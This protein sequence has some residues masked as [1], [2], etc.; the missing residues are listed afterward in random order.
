MSKN[1]EQHEYGALIPKM[2]KAQ[3]NDLYKSIEANGLNH[4]IVLFEGKVLDGWNRYNCCQEINK[5]PLDAVAIRYRNFDGS[6]QQALEFVLS[7]NLNRRHIAEQD[8][9][10]VALKVRKELMKL[11]DADKPQGKID[12][13]AGKAAGVPERT[14]SRAARVEKHGS[15]DV[16]KAMTEG[17]ITP[18]AAEKILKADK[19][20]QK[21]LVEK[22]KKT[23]GKARAADLAAALKSSMKDDSGRAVPKDLQDI[24]LAGDEI[25]ACVQQIKEIQRMLNK[26]GKH[27][28]AVHTEVIHRNLDMVRSTLEA[29]MP[30]WVCRGCEGTGKKEGKNCNICKTRG[31]VAKNSGKMPQWD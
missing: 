29:N 9:I 4:E 28:P 26:A 6:Q 2:S 5:N 14:V 18:R 20:E 31:Y 12:A 17:D 3:Y 8:R 22:A 25:H 27:V 10:K 21:N 13:A 16:K 1:Y 11:A 19:K 23:G 15:E 30:A 24:F 7:E